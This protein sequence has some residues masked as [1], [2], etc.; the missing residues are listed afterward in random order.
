MT[1][2]NKI[3]KYTKEILISSSKNTSKV[4]INADDFGITKGVNKAI[5]ELVD[6]GVVTSTSVMSNM[7]YFED[8]IKL[9]NTIGIG[10]HL[11]LTTGKPLNN[12]KMV[13]SLVSENGEFFELSTLLKRIWHGQISKKAVEF[14][15]NAQIQQLFDLGIHPDHIDSHE[16]ILKY[17]FIIRIVKEIAKTYDIFAVRTFIPR[18][19]DYRRLLSP[20]KMLISLYLSYQRV[21]WKKYGFSVGDKK[22]SLLEVGL[23]YNRAIDKLKNVFNNLPDGVLEFTVHPG[24]CNEDNRPLGGYI[25]EREVEMQALLSDE[26]KDIVSSSEAELISFK[27]IC[28][29]TF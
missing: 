7:P 23:N 25:Q 6:A 20:K 4:I 5:F 12:V 15:L 11:N 21:L 22:D 26:F 3:R 10:V 18:K 9:K 16:S 29:N 8:I 28:S 27:D 24:Y 13:S 19:F 1:I 2:I 14:E 17:P